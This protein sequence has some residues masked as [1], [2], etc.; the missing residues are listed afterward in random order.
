MLNEVRQRK[1]NTIWYHLYAE[2]KK[3][4]KL[5]NVT[6]KK[7]THRYTEQTSGYQGG[8]GEE[9]YRGGELKGTNY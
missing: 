9:Q 4:N 3:C 7:Q 2:S 6:K 5:V 1:T 8:R